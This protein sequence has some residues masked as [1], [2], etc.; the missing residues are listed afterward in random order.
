MLR[1]E[2]ACGF[3]PRLGRL[4]QADGRRVRLASAVAAVI[5]GAGLVAAAGYLARGL[6]KPAP[7]AFRAGLDALDLPVGRVAMVGDDVENDV[8]AAQELGITG[9]LV[10]T[11]KFRVEDLARASGAPDLV[12]NSV[13][14]VPGLLGL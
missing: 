2:R 7:A 4:P 10:R 13:R 6:R 1:R 5:S 11:G 14:V 12:V 9:I 8:L 3:R